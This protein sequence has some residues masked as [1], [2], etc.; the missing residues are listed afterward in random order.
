MFPEGFGTE[1]TLLSN[2][3]NQGFEEESKVTTRWPPSVNKC[4]R[5]TSETMTGRDRD[6]TEAL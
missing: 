6:R 4:M 1:L 2:G 3:V 5:R